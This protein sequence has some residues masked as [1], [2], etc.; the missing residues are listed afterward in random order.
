M[1]AVYAT[2]KTN[3]LNFEREILDDLLEAI[4]LVNIIPYSVS[5]EASISSEFLRVSQ[6]VHILHSRRWLICKLKQIK[7]GWTLTLMMYRFDNR[8]CAEGTVYVKG[9]IYDLWVNSIII[10]LR[11]ACCILTLIW[12][13]IGF[14]ACTPFQNIHVQGR[15]LT[16]HLQ[17][18]LSMARNFI[19]IQE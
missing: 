6:Q 1:T 16:K 15:P 9:E 3:Q 11:N 7:N 8:V 10:F 5:R 4:F 12:S 18:T 17:Y 19:C 13:L 2:T 14:K